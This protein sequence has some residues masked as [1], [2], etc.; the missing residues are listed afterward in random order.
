MLSF[1]SF[2]ILQ[3]ACRA[4]GVKTVFPHLDST[5]ENR[6]TCQ[7][8][9]NILRSDILRR[10]SSFGGV[11]VDNCSP[12]SIKLVCNTGHAK[13]LNGRAFSVNRTALKAE[14]EN[15]EKETSFDFESYMDGYDSLIA[16]K[17]KGSEAWLSEKSKIV[18][19]VITAVA[20]EAFLKEHFPNSSF[21]LTNSR[22]LNELIMG[23][24]NAA[25]FRE[26][27]SKDSQE[28]RAYRAL[29]N[30]IRSTA[31]QMLCTYCMANMFAR[32]NSLGVLKL[33]LFNTSD[34]GKV[35]KEIIS[36]NPLVITSNEG[37]LF[38][39]NRSVLNSSLIPI[40]GNIKGLIS[41]LEDDTVD[42]ASKLSEFL[43]MLN[44]GFESVGLDKDQALANPFFFVFIES[45]S[46]VCKRTYSGLS[47]DINNVDFWAK[48]SL[49]SVLNNVSQEYFQ[50]FRDGARKAINAFS[51]PV[52]ANKD[53]RVPMYLQSLLAD[54][55]SQSRSIDMFCV[56]R[57]QTLNATL[58]GEKGSPNFRRRK[59]NILSNWKKKR[60]K[61][62]IIHLQILLDPLLFFDAEMYNALEN[63]VFGKD[64]KV[65]LKANVRR[66]KL[67]M[68]AAEASIK[69]RQECIDV[70]NSQLQGQ[71][72]DVDSKGNKFMREK[73][74]SDV[75]WSLLPIP[76]GILDINLS[77][78]D[79]LQP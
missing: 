28:S 75:N 45:I 26:G 9:A 32:D 48:G 16:S 69:R 12:A 41:F 27:F 8:E 53:L 44:A 36:L 62:E 38:R 22:S 60:S 15:S 66:K 19:G 34:F 18:D 46:D 79:T 11:S 64:G 24:V 4:F 25:P 78:R 47:I 55:Y 73:R 65:G 17:A 10:S 49:N 40:K 20:T 39:L 56:K 63:K 76:K 77:K 30:G 58:G 71:I 43:G 33:V 5:S 57:L 52:D 6:T 21:A 37:S 54:Y 42:H 68:A 61:H 13:V 29:V 31:K 2:R 14:A 23:V 7:I 3:Q 67:R 50:V 51:A 72:S 35:F 59:D 74:L 70:I 1:S